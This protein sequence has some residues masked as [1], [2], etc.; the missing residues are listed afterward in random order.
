LYLARLDF[1]VEIF[2]ARK[3]ASYFSPLERGGGSL[4]RGGR[5]TKTHSVPACPADVGAGID[6]GSKEIAA[7]GQNEGI[8]DQP[9]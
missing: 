5:A 4:E 8:G 2:I 7:I 1:T 6:N 3:R 9:K